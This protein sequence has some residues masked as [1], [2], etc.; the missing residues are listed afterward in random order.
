MKYLNIIGLPLKDAISKIDED[1]S[2]TIVE[3]KGTNNRFNNNL[4]EL[5]VVKFDIDDK[6]IKIIVCAF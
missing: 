6:L 1:L 2:I 5:R 4:N 3:T